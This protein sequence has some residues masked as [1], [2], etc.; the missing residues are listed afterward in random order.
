MEVGDR[1]WKFFNNKLC[2]II[3]DGINDL[4]VSYH[5]EGFEDH[6][7]YGCI[8]IIKCMTFLNEKDAIEF[9]LKKL[10]HEQEKLEEKI[11]ETRQMLLPFM[12]F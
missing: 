2:S 7:H 10:Y 5:Y 8:N 1:R 3:I 9:R 4:S 6:I 12:E 11:Y